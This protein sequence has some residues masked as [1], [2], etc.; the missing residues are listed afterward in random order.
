MSANTFSVG[1]PW[2]YNVE[3]EDKDNYV[4]PHYANLKS[5]ICENKSIAN[6]KQIYDIEI[7]KKAKAYHQTKLVKS[8]RKTKYDREK[9]EL[10]PTD[11]ISIAHLICIILYT[12][13]TALSA[14]FSSTF[15]AINKYE[16]HQSIKKRHEK[17]YWMSK[18]LKEVMCHFYQDHDVDRGLLDP[19]R[20]PFF[21][22]MNWVMNVNQ[23]NITLYGPTST[24]IERSVAARFGGQRGFLIQFDNTNGDGKYVRGFDVSWLSRFGSQEEERYKTIHLFLTFLQIWVYQNVIQTLYA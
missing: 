15:R 24:S 17:Y 16:P 9:M 8:I 5:E 19:L 7:Y 18:G 1:I 21:C 13:Y 12:D 4:A 11:M 23:F 2:I 14:S 3:D 6:V 20:G 22:G 10:V